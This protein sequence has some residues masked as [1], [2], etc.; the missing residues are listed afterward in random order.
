M[1]RSC[2]VFLTLTCSILALIAQTPTPSPALPARLDPA[3]K[4]RVIFK[5]A[6][7]LKR[8]YVDR[9]LGA[10]M[11]A[12]LL[13]RERKGDYDRVRDPAEFA[14]LL[15]RQ[16]R[17]LSND[18]QIDVLYSRT[19]L[20]HPAGTPEE[21][22]RIGPP[23]P[24]YREAMQQANCTFE[25]IEL[26]PHNVG[27]VKLDSFP[28]PSV[29]GRTAAEAMAKLNDAD[30]VIFD[31]RDNR[32]GHP[33]MVALIAA[34]L[35]DHPEYLYNP[36][37]NTTAQ[38]WT[39]SPI[40]GN[41]LADKPAYVLTSRTTISGAEQFTYNL[42]MLKRATIVGETTAGGAHAGV[43]YRIDNHFGV[44]ITEVKA[45]NPYG[46]HGWEVSG[47]EPDVKV[48][49]AQALTTAKRL[50]ESRMGKP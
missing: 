38:S 4:H 39:R 44:G 3:T 18:W 25:K 32:G 17:D 43:F 5:V 31:L 28:D 11:A 23:L 42:K 1:A 45:I 40:P 29:C 6:E 7:N 12:A 2:L 33:K 8:H 48:N 10:R 47:V 37:E 41:K 50:A 9:G 24:G 19:P 16:L 26:L 14:A 27:Y 49:A 46:Q 15:A 36:R 13:A 34:Y 22:A 30:A 35:F 20:P 21:L